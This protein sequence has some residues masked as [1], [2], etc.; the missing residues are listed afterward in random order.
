MKLI[1]R[2][3]TGIIAF[4]KICEGGFVR[5][6]VNAILGGPGAGKTTF[7]LQFLWNGIKKYGENGL[8]VSFEPDI[9]ELREDALMFGWDFEKEENKGTC[10]FIKL[11]TK[12]SVSDLKAE[13]MKIVAK[14]DIRRICMDPAS[15]LSSNIDGKETRMLIYDLVSLL[16]RLKVTVILANE[17]PEGDLEM[18]GKEDERD[19]FVRFLSDSCTSFYSS[20]LGGVT[21]RALRV[22]KMRRTN[23]LRGPIPFQITDTGINVVTK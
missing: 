21:D 16:K 20:G 15:L 14:Y 12:S 6:S 10:K 5:N 22:V 23:H 18:P 9:E 8:F 11:S 13:L 2:C 3:P 7:L 4:D 19:Y 17:T 1:E